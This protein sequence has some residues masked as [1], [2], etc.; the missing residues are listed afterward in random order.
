VPNS[1][2]L[3][4]S[5]NSIQV[6]KQKSSPKIAVAKVFWLLALEPHRYSQRNQVTIDLT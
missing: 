2:F 5:Q 1:A 3:R 6:L 4:R